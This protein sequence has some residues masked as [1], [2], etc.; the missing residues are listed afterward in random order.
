MKVGV[1][2][3]KMPIALL[4]AAALCFGLA[5]SPASASFNQQAPSSAENGAKVPEHLVLH[6]IRFDGKSGQLGVGSKAEL[7]DAAE[8]VKSNPRTRIFVGSNDSSS[9]CGLSTP[10]AKK[11]ASYMKTR[12]VPA[13]H[14]SLCH[15]NYPNPNRS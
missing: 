15:A 4:G 9:A 14:I 1:L 6:G 11:I 5:M 13:D 7:D 8:I 3:R 12:G 2:N 10:E